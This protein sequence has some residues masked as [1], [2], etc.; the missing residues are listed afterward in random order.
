MSGEASSPSAI[1]AVYQELPERIIS[2]ARILDE[3]LICD[4]PRIDEK[5]WRES[6]IHSL[7]SPRLRLAALLL[8]TCRHLFRLP[9]PHPLQSAIRCTRYVLHDLGYGLDIIEPVIGILRHSYLILDGKP[10]SP[11]ELRA[12]SQVIDTGG[13]VTLA[14]LL[15]TGTADKLA[16]HLN[17][18]GCFG[19]RYEALDDTYPSRIRR[20]ALKATLYGK[21]SSNAVDGDTEPSCSGVLVVTVGIPGSGKT[22][23]LERNLP[24]A[25]V[26]SMDRM[27]QVALGNASD[28]RDND[29]IYARAVSAVRAH[30]ERGGKVVFD[31]TSYSRERRRNLGKIAEKTGA[32]VRMIY[33]DV[34]FAEAIR[35]IENRPRSVPENVVLDMYRG[36]DL[37]EPDEADDVVIVSPV[38]KEPRLWSYGRQQWVWQAEPVDPQEAGRQ[39]LR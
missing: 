2:A 14:R 23:W 19:T 39:L 24:D 13:L 7:P 11:A 25:T 22:T 4:N 36:I 27:R 12:V 31:A 6:D 37:P 1:E 15:N 16:A 38:W 3:Q 5:L 34:S 9:F 17:E 35:R 8:T 26:I 33:F 28:Q 21:P 18:A 10:T 30:L 32:C 20:Q 29:R